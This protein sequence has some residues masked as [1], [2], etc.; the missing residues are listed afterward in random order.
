VNELVL[1]GFPTDRLAFR[2][3]GVKRRQHDQ[4]K[5][6]RGQQAADDDGCKRLLHLGAGARRQPIG[7]NP[8]E[9]TTGRKRVSAPSLIAISEGLPASIND[10][11]CVNMT[12]PLRTA[13]P[14]SAMK[15]DRGGYREWHAA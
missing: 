4:R 11:I 14:D 7:T 13:T 2:K 15:P 1:P 3:L 8:S 9:V 12:S 6:R 10:R 5:H